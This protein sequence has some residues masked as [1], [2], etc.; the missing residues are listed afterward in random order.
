MIYQ[1]LLRGTAIVSL[2]LVSACSSFQNPQPNFLGEHPSISAKSTHLIEKE[3]EK[4]N[5]KIIT[6]KPLPIYE[7]QF[8]TVSVGDS[9]I[10]KYHSRNLNSDVLKKTLEEQL[11][12]KVEGISS[13]VETNQILIRTKKGSGLES[14]LENLIKS[15]DVDA[16]QIMFD[17]RIVKVFADYTRDKSSA[18]SLKSKEGEGLFPALM[19]NLPGASLRVPERAAE[20]GL[21]VKYGVLGETSK[22]LINAQLDQLQS[23]GFA[24]DLA[25]T[26]LVVSSGKKG[27]IRLV[28]ELPYI[29]RSFQAG[30]IFEATKYKEI[31]NFLEITPVMRDDGNIYLDINAGVGSYNP[32]GVLQVPGIVR[33]NVHL[34]GV[35]IH[36]NET[37]VLGGFRID[38]TLV[39]ERKDPWFSRIPVA[40][41]LFKAEDREKSTNEVIFIATPRYLDVNKN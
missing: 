11:C 39:V 33:R 4:I 3:K 31:D 34:F 41:Y 20:L 37:I 10:L 25:A 13:V 7:N 18:L 24:E 9:E 21:G 40:G 22:Y 38:H 12:G 8:E 2:G 17:L 6:E 14:Q 35:K 16:P 36:E 15:I 19:A 32:T 27:E 1:K 23:Q 26:T 5:V 30:T 28:Q 29:E